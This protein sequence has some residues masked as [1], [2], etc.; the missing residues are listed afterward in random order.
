MDKTKVSGTFD[1]SSILLGAT[2]FESMY[3][4]YVIKSNNHDFHYK[5]HC[6][7]LSVRLKQHNEGLT[8]SIK[9][10]LPFEIVYFEEFNTRPEAIAR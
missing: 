1:S 7:D 9:P 3:Y 2:R 4:A 6:E 8:K 5:G 10:Y